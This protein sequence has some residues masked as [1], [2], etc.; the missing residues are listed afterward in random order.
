MNS[1]QRLH[2]TGL[3]H[4]HLSQQGLQP[5]EENNVVTVQSGCEVRKEDPG[6][7]T[8]QESGGNS[9]L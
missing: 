7:D 3:L 9:K 2:M 5:T 4:A 1:V 6:A 8:G